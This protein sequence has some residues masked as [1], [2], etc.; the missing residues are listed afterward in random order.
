VITVGERAQKIE[1]R[2]LATMRAERDAAFG[3]KK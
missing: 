3:G 2:I 1:E